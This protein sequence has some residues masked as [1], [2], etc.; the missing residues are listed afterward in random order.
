MVGKMVL[1]LYG[2]TSAVWNTCMVFFQT[3]LL[4]GY[5]YAHIS[6]KW[7]GTR[8]QAI[9]HFFLL[10]LPILVLPILITQDT[11]P[12]T[13]SDP[14]V[15]LLHKLFITVG[16]PFF[17]LSSSAPLL[18]RWFSETTH[19]SSSDP[20]F[21]YAASNAGSLL[22]LL[23]YPLILEPYLSLTEQSLSWNLG[24]ILV[25]VMM[26]ICG[27]LF[28]RSH[29]LQNKQGNQAA[30]GKTLQPAAQITLRQRLFWIFAAFIPSSLMLSVTLYITTNIASVPLL[31]IVPLILYLLTFVMVFARTQLLSHLW[32]GRIIPFIII[33]AAPFFFY[34]IKGGD[35]LLIPIHLLIFSVIALICHGEL[36]R[37]RPEPQH[38]TEFY[39]LMSFGGVLGGLFNA[40]VAPVFFNRIIEY[41]L[42]VF[43]ACF[44][45]PKS[46]PEQQNTLERKLDVVLPLAIACF[47]ST[48]LFVIH[49][50]DLQPNLFF[51]ALL[52]APSA[53]ACFGFKERL[54]RFS[55]AFGVV[56]VSLAYFYDFSVGRQIYATRNFFGVKKVV[57]NQEDNIRSLIHG[58]VTHGSQFIDASRSDEPLTYYHQSGPIGDIFLLFNRAYRNQNVA[59]IGLGVGSIASYSMPGQ[60]FVFYEIDPAIELIARNDDYFTFLATSKGS[61]DIV[62]G[63]GRL[64]MKNAPE[65]SYGMIILDAFSSD[66]IPV[67]LLTKEAI[68][69]YLAKLDAQ[70]IIAFHISNNYVNLEPVLSNLAKELGLDCLVKHDVLTIKDEQNHGKYPSDYVVMG[71]FTPLIKQSLINAKWQK[72]TSGHSNSIWTD[73]YSNIAR[74]LKALM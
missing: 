48:I 72:A 58:T 66:A 33:P 17:V 40:L 61:Y 4:L 35:L 15:W 11:V 70:G 21:L 54:V 69:L 6:V 14:V 43:L 10:F 37:S 73:Q 20:Y 42:L 27:I 52:Y 59:I 45:L 34:S 68:M 13:E 28:W 3:M 1:P 18:Q 2:G 44:I 71:R 32:L 26:L 8:L 51:F 36:A 53:L 5:A 56:L 31:W 23:G 47:A 22:G 19:P 39:L 25:I 60:H 16:L 7:L 24:Y 38:L 55:L 57:L 41:P 50:F 9:A 63:D 29:A 30:G 67:H 46:H 49:A 12:S 62:I 65:H 74:S 64:T